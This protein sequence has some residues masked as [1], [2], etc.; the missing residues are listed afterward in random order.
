L[1]RGGELKDKSRVDTAGKRKREIEK[2][3]FVTVVTRL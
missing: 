3:E 2:L 1:F